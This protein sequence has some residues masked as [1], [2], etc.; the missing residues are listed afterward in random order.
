MVDLSE[1]FA[2]IGYHD[3]NWQ[4]RIWSRVS[5]GKIG[6]ARVAI[7][8]LG[9]RANGVSSQQQPM[10]CTWLGAATGCTLVTLAGHGGFL[11][12]RVSWIDETWSFQ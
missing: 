7:V 12:F 5:S 6:V 10:H 1:R 8:F 3:E 9:D 4:A 11:F 2:N